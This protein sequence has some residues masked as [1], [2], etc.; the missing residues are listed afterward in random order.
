MKGI[1]MTN[2]LPL[3]CKS[4]IKEGIR[5]KEEEPEGSGL[6]AKTSSSETSSPQP[7]PAANVSCQ[8]IREEIVK[9]RPIFDTQQISYMRLSLLNPKATDSDGSTYTRLAFNMDMSINHNTKF[10]KLK[11]RLTQKR[12]EFYSNIPSDWEKDIAYSS[13]W[14]HFNS[15][16][17]NKWIGKACYRKDG[18]GTG[19]KLQMVPLSSM[20]VWMEGETMHY[21]IWLENV[22][23]EGVIIYNQLKHYAGYSEPVRRMEAT[24]FKLFKV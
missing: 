8:W 19:L 16:K 6:L 18:K 10:D 1:K 14:D 5:N 7:L 2:V 22:E 17:G 15:I 20:V 11:W 23:V 4:N 3:I 21:K 12:S 9:S 24:T 13:A